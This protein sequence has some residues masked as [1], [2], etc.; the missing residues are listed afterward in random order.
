[1]QADKNSR[2]DSSGDQ[3]KKFLLCDICHLDI[4]DVLTEKRKV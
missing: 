1:M 3:L 4:L 2:L